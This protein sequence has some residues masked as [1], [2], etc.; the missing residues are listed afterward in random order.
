M[1]EGKGLT[2]GS[3]TDAAVQPFGDDEPVLE[4]VDP[5]AHGEEA[6]VGLA[7][8]C[9]GVEERVGDVVN[10]AWR[11]LGPRGMRDVLMHVDVL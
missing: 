1:G 4:L 7:H 10:Y 3:A 5:F 2:A 9:E 11:G 6:L 8:A